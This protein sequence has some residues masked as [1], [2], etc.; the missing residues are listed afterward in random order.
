[1]ARLEGA[2]DPADLAIVIPLQCPHCGTDGALI[3]GYGPEASQAEADV[4]TAM[5]RDVRPSAAD[6]VGRPVEPQVDLLDRVGSPP[7]T[8]R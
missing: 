5:P 1:V 2:S 4:L 6:V 7:I 3:A 8:V